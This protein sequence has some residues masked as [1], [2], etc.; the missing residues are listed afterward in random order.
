MTVALTMS[1]KLIS[2]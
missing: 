1:F 2:F